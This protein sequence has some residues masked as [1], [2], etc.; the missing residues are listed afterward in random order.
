MTERKEFF[1]TNLV[2]DERRFKIDGSNGYAYYWH[3]IKDKERMLGQ[4]YFSPS[5]TVFFKRKINIENGQI[6]N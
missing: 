2:S 6:N 4:R 3:D 5:I 1:K